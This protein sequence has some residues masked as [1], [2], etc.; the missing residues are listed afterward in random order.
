MCVPLWVDV[1]VGRH[2][3]YTEEE[4]FARGDGLVEKTAGFGSD[5][6]GGVLIVMLYGGIVVVLVDGGEIGVCTRVEEEVCR[7]PAGRIGG[8]VILCCMGVE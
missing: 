2:W 5:E 3:G 6:V 8:V 4:R 1:G 7:C